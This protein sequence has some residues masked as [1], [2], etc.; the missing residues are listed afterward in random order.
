MFRTVALNSLSRASQ[1][2]DRKLAK[3]GVAA[4]GNIQVAGRRD[5]SPTP[6]RRSSGYETAYRLN[7]L[8][9]SAPRSVPVGPPPP[10][11]CSLGLVPM[12]SSHRHVR[13]LALFQMMQHSG[14]VRRRRIVRHHH[15][16]LTEFLI[17]AR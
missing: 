1:A 6:T 12:P 11:A 16:R 2:D 7:V 3:N 14:V 13:Q 17:Q 4:A 5:R 10:G 9:D 15:N 8:F